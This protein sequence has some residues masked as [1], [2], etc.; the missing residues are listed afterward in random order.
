MKQLLAA[1]FFFV[2]FFSFYIT[3]T[4]ATDILYDDFSAPYLDGEK[5]RTREYVREVIDGKLISKIGNSSSSVNSGEFAPGVF[6]NSLLFAN[7]GTVNSIECKVTIVETHL[8]TATGSQS[9]AGIFGNF[10]NKNTI[11]GATGDIGAGVVIGDRGSGLEAVWIVWEILTDD[12]TGMKTIGSGTIPGNFEYNKPY[13]LKLTYGGNNIFF[14]TANNQEDS[15]TTGPARERDAVVPF[16]SIDTNIDAENGSNNGFIHAEFDDV[17]VNNSTSIYD[18]FSSTLNLSKWNLLEEIREIS[19][20]SLRMNIQADGAGDRVNAVLSHSDTD[21]FETK[22][23]L[24]SQSIQSLG[25]VGTARIMGFYYNDSRG[26]GSGLPFNG[27]EGNVFAHVRLENDNN[28]ILGCRVGL[29]R[30]DDADQ[31]NWTHLFD[32]LFTTPIYFDTDYTL[33]IRFIDNQFIFKCDNETIIYTV[34]TPKYLPYGGYR[35]LQTRLW[36]DSGGSG[37]LKTSYDDVRVSEDS[38]NFCLQ[39]YDFDNDMDGKDAVAFVQDSKDVLIEDFAMHF[40]R[41][42]CP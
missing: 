21:F 38:I 13:N 22:T 17:Y 30:A 27:H 37:Y 26:P 14:F 8:D 35:V 2:L 29:F 33:S 11:G 28:G 19:D 3:D 16:K 25:A 5:W 31:I 9:Y 20:G 12:L 41:T 18:D 1:L 6:R 42:D 39:D 4:N 34:S 36:L 40:G 15:F 7:P 23:R 24:S 32:E 10:Y